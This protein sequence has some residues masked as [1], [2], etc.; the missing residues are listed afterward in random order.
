MRFAFPES[1]V[2]DVS[3]DSRAVSAARLNED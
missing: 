2:P 1:V 3:V